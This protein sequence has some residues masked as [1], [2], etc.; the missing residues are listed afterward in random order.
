MHL[1]KDMR[2]PTRKSEA[3]RRLHEQDDAFFSAAAIAKMKRELEQLVQVDRPQAA[4]EV[5][6]TGE[7]GDFSENAAYQFAKHQLRRIN[8]RITTLEERLKHAIA[9]PSGSAVDGR[10]RLGS[11]VRLR[12]NGKEIEFEI[13]GTHE[14]SPG[15]GR[16]SHVSP[17]GQALLGH[18]LGETVSIAS[19]SGMIEYEILSIQ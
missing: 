2:L 19:P 9:I 17:L 7:M 16:I 12:S 18:T 1:N 8:A 10:V 4:A 11:R 13:L 15:R 5:R 6:R 14:T 3:V